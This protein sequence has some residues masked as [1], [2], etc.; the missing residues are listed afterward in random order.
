MDLIFR[1]G[2]EGNVFI[3]MGWWPYSSRETREVGQMLRMHPSGVEG[4]LLVEW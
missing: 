2:G 4:D 1:S 3:L